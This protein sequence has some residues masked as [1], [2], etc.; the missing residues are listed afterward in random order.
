MLVAP[1]AA[2]CARIA[3]GSGVDND[4][5]NNDEEDREDREGIEGAGAVGVT[6]DFFFFFFFFFFALRPFCSSAAVSRSLRSES[7]DFAVMLC[8]RRDRIKEVKVLWSSSPAIRL[9]GSLVFA[10]I[11]SDHFTSTTTAGR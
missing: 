9:T 8:G 11:W 4:N 2:G 1:L 10:P 3:D 6:L 7:S 5:D